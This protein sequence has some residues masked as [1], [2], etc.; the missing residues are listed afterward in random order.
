VVGY[1]R[2]SKAK[3]ND[4]SLPAQQEKIK[5]WA[6]LNN[7]QVI[8]MFEDNGIS[9]TRADNRPGIQQALEMTIENQA[10]LVIY[11]LSR[12]FR[13]TID[14]ITNVNRIKKAGAEFVSLSENLDTTSAAGRL[15]FRI[16]A[17]LAEF[18]A[19]LA[20]ERTKIALDYRRSKGLKTGG[21]APY[22]YDVVDE[23]GRL[24]K[25]AVEQRVI[26][27]MR[28][29][30]TR[31]HSLSHIAKRLNERGIRTKNGCRWY[32]QTVKNILNHKPIN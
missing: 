12:S 21:Y 17:S 6:A 26:G 16:F 22:G 28:R 20:G 32:A 14:A 10:V 3:D 18:E 9:G 13:S 1:C 4:V 24:Q 25:N 29:M 8:G 23:E 2:I 7:A 15:I 27:Y 31:G 11:S 30:I 5:Q 19:D